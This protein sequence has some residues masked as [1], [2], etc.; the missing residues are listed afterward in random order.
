M[1]GE[2]PDS[3]RIDKWLWYARFFKTRSLAAK[4]V[5]SG[6]VRVTVGEARPQ[7]VLKGSQLVRC[8][9]VLTFSHGAEIRVVRVKATGLRRG[10]A[11]EA[12]LLYEDVTSR[13]ENPPAPKPLSVAPSA[14][15]RPAGSGRPTKRD[16]RAIDRIMNAAPDSAKTR[17]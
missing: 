5:A 12:R 4:V 11:S 9:D 8:G 7:R 14:P 2:M 6:K 1:T 3:Q 13:S 16:R 10:P 15:E 17:N